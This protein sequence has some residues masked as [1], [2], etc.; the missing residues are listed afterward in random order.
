MHSF[1]PLP[2]ITS[3]DNDVNNIKGSLILRAFLIVGN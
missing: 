3:P 2:L 1:P